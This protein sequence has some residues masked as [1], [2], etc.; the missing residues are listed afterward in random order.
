MQKDMISIVW[1][2]D[3][4]VQREEIDDQHRRLFAMLADFYTQLQ[5]GAGREVQGKMLED[6]MSYAGDHFA[7]E[8]MLLQEHPDFARHRQLHYGFIKKMNAFER[9]YLHGD[10]TLGVEMVD[11]VR[12]WLCEHIAGI[13]RRQ[14]ADL[15]RDQ[16]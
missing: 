3:L 10:I 6:L 4:E 13:D 16:T 8:E 12:R 7:T 1:T 2:E 14:F 9:S 11:F 15:R 5:K